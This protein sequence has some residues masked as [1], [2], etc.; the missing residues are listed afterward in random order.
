VELSRQRTFG[1]KEVEV[2]SQQGWAM[3][4]HG[5]NSVGVAF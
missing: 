5:R 4:G 2:E 1:E 3:R